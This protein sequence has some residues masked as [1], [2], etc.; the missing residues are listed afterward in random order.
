MAI[1]ALA[2]TNPGGEAGT[3]VGWTQRAGLGALQTTGGGPTFAPQPHT[4]AGAFHFSGFN[5]GQG[6]Y[7]QQVATPP[8]TDAAVDAGIAAVR[9]SV[10]TIGNTGGGDTS[11]PYISFV[12]GDGVTIISTAAM[13]QEGSAPYKKREQYLHVP[14]NTRFL[15]IGTLHS[16]NPGAGDF[17]NEDDYELDFSDAGEADWPAQFAPKAHQLGAYAFAGSEVASGLFAVTASQLGVLAWVSQPAQNVKEHQGG[18]LAFA[19]SEVASGLFRVATHQIGAYAWV[20]GFPDRRDLRAWHFVQDDHPFTVFQLGDT[21]TLIHDRLT[22]QWAQWRS[23]GFA[24][25]RGDDGCAWEGFNVCCDRRSGRIFKIDPV[26]RLDFNNTTGLND[27]PIVS[28]VTGMARGNRM[29][30]LVACY[31]AEL[32]VS[33]GDPPP[34]IAEGAVG[35]QLRTS[36]DDGRNWLD[37]GT[38][39][40]GGLDEDVSIRWYG[41]G[42]MQC[43]GRVFEITDSGYARRIDALDVEAG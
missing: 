20:K 9:M 25:W 32:V 5:P 35:I 4:G 33:E 29:R 1:T 10:W 36:D 37:H 28:I 19:A 22:Q 41:L 12:Q 2:L 42:L 6:K 15:R 13:A 16:P 40:G 31:M 7:D 39:P 38:I 18:I 17:A 11:A 26:G 30:G 8:G 43:P 14:A 23:A 27:T 3:P 34:G 24:Y 21:L